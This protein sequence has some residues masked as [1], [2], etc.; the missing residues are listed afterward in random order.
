MNNLDS[1]YALSGRRALMRKPHNAR[2]AITAL[3]TRDAIPGDLAPAVVLDASGRVRATYGHWEKATGKLKRL[4]SVA[5]S[6]HNL[7]V[8]V[9]DKGSGK[10][11]WMSNGATLAREVA[12]MIDSKPTED[13]LV[14][15]QIGVNGGTIPDQIMGLLST[16]ADRFSFLN[17]GKHQ[18]TN[19]FRNIQNVILAGLNNH[20]E[21]DYE[22][23]AR[24]YSGIRNY[25][26]VPKTLVQDIEAGEQKHH[27]LQALR[28]SAVICVSTELP[29]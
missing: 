25:Q 14:V 26:Q 9:M 13:W 11:A 7:S 6:Y 2:Q 19:E 1:L 22:M 23:K 20:P 28:R 3:D 15:Y 10:N 24:Y 17:W 18:G 4:P 29:N 12:Q 5:R 21:T 27:I 8:H 16:N